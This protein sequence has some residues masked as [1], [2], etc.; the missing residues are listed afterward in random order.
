MLKSV[1]GMGGELGLPT[2]L[3]LLNHEEVRRVDGSVT[4]TCQQE[5]GH[6][7]LQSSTKG[8]ERG[9]LRTQ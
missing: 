2:Q 8:S 3:A 9:S 5:P 1:N 6:G 7:V 4:H